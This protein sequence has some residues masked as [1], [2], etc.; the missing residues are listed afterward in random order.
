MN[1]IES[2][3]HVSHAGTDGPPDLNHEQAAILAYLTWLF[4][5]CPEGRDKRNWYDAEQGLRT[6]QYVATSVPGE[7]KAMKPKQELTDQ[8]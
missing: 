1:E 5:G 4:E 3:P 7:L 6:E 2:N 8:E